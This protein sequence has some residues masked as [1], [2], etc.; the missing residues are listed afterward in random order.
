ME[1]RLYII[2][3]PSGVGKGT[4]VKELLKLDENLALSISCTT[5][6]PRAGE[7]DGVDYFFLTRDEFL[8]RVEADGFLEYDEHF[9]NYYGTPKDFVREQMKEKSVILE[10]DVVGALNVQ[11]RCGAEFSPR[12]HPRRPAR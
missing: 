6:K 7:K 5:R 8:R 3:G 11:K 9:G 12:A 4:L 10:I 1:H 2:S